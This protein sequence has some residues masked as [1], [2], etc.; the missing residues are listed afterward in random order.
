M[1]VTLPRR[2]V[3]LNGSASSDDLAIDSW[4]W[5]RESES[6][7][8]G[9]VVGDSDRSNLLMVLL[10]ILCTKMNVLTKFIFYLVG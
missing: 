2:S 10:L 5:T 4:L 6:L 9:M 1:T 7:A 3:Y 8:A